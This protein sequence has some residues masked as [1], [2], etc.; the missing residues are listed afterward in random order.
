MLFKHLNRFT[1]I[2]DIIKNVCAKSEQLSHHKTALCRTER[3]LLSKQGDPKQIFHC[4]CYCY[5]KAVRDKC[6]MIY[7]FL[8]HTQ[9]K[10][11]LFI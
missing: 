9:K 8:L 3:K 4:H 2:D 10:C 6:D 1:A 7:E 11:Q 5:E